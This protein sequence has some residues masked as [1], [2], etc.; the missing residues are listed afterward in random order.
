MSAQV[1]QKEDAVL[2]GGASSL[3]TREAMAVE[4]AE[5]I[6]GDPHSVTGDFW[7]TL[8]GEFTDDELVELT[9]ACS[10]FNWGNK[11]NITMQLD[12]DGTTYPSSMEYREVAK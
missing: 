12:T 4:L 5:R 1:K 8:K 6:A 11:F 9:F 10:I 3:T 2:G 7:E